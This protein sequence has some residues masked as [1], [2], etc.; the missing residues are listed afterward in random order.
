MN[1]PGG[2]LTFESFEDGSVLFSWLVEGDYAKAGNSGI[3]GGAEYGVT[4]S[5]VSTIVNFTEGQGIRFR[6]RVSCES[7]EDTD[8]F[9]VF[10][11][12]SPI[13]VWYGE[14]DWDTYTLPVPAGEHEIAWCY[15]KDVQNSEGE[16][17]AYLD[18]VELVDAELYE[19]EHSAELD[20]A[21]NLDGGT[22]EFMTIA[23][24]ENGYFPWEAVNGY[25]KSTNEGVDANPTSIS[26]MC[27]TIN[28]NEGDVLRFSYRVS[29]EERGDKLCVYLDDERILN[30]SG[31]VDWN[32][33]N[34]ELTTGIH[35]IRWEYDKD[36]SHS[37]DEDAAFI[38]NVYVGTPEPVSG[39]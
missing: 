25:A 19:L 1:V 4:Q 22:L 23:E 21:L 15:N 9:A 20:A 11:D 28:S 29:S 32:V 10:I 26:M 13:E 5:T 24:L 3:D 33:F 39:V 31:D 27:T 35:E 30:V 18:D 34:Y 16:D 14:M 17:I 36:Y 7:T 8:W 38:D 12:N 37:D 2:N 6:Y